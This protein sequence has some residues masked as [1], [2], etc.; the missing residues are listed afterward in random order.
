MIYTLDTNVLID[1]LRRPAEMLLLK[2][3]FEWALPHTSL[4]SVVASELLAGARTESARRLVERDLLDAFERRGRIV[5]PSAAA[6][7]KTGLVL[8]RATTA[9]IGASWQND[10]LLAHTVREF[11]WTLITRD[12]DFTRIRPLVKGLRV[13]APYPR[14]HS[15]S[16]DAV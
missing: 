8:G 9:S 1:A 13:E 3:F 14:R 12:K 6:W 7:S 16:R 11:G 2:E 4:S 10:L 15:I 5:A